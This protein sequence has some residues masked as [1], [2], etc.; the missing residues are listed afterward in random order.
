MG[1]PALGEGVFVIDGPVV[2]DMGIRFTT[3]MTVV[4]LRDGA[5]WPSSPAPSHRPSRR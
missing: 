4:R 3:R 2:R 1:L 5:V